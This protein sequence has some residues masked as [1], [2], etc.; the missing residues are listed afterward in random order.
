[1]IC[2]NI[3]NILKDQERIKRFKITFIY[4]EYSVQ[5]GLGCPRCIIYLH[6]PQWVKCEAQKI[7]SHAAPDL[8][9]AAVASLLQE[10]FTL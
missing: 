1:M 9:N 10:N 5:L 3:A 2:C 6:T 4:I 8:R 7:L